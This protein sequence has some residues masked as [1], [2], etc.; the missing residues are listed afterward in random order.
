MHD[1]NVMNDS[2]WSPKTSVEDTARPKSL[3]VTLCNPAEIPLIDTEL[4][5]EPFTACHNIMLL[6]ERQKENLLKV[7]CRYHG[8]E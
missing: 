7:Q 4:T 2:R 8:T 3:Y 5:T 6:C 1:G